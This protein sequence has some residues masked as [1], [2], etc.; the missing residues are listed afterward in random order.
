MGI[1]INGIE[2]FPP[3][4]H[5]WEPR[6]I[7]GTSG[8]GHPFYSSVLSYKMHW[9]LLSTD[10]LKVLFSLASGSSGTAT[11]ELPQYG[12]IYSFVSYSG[13]IVHEPEVSNYFQGYVTD[14]NLT[15]SNIRI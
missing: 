4:E 15:I 9:D 5:G 7:I 8:D 14:V 12:D 2:I 3:T 13:C 10:E 1:K 11:C 6:N